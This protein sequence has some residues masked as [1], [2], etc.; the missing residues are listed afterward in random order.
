MVSGPFSRL[1]RQ[2]LRALGWV[3]AIEAG[4]SCFFAWYWGLSAAA[5]VAAGGMAVW[6]PQLWMAVQLTQPSAQWNPVALGVA[7][8]TMSGLLFAVWFS[9]VPSSDWAPVMLGTIVV[10]IATPIATARASRNG[11]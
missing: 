9:L 5:G 2:L 1:R 3:L 8:Y 7:K 4:L 10:L 11:G 6:L